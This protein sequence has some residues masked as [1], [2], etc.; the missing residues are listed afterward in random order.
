MVE[1]VPRSDSTWRLSN[2]IGIDK[3]LTDG[4][5]PLLALCECLV[6]KT[7]ETD[8]TMRN[9]LRCKVGRI[10]VVWAAFVF[11]LAVLTPSGRTAQGPDTPE[12]LMEGY[13]QQAKVGDPAF[14]GFSTER[15]RKFYLEKH[16][17]MGVGAVSCASCHRKDPRE[18]VRAHIAWL[19]TVDGEALYPAGRGTGPTR[20]LE[21]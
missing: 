1:L 19:L 2:G 9:M 5:A 13:L 10:G 8:W 6:Y 3:F 20:A 11:G 16:A 14:E 21:E 17:L 7:T 18:Q 4:L 12:Q 15:G